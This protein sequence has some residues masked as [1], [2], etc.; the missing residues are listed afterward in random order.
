MDGELYE[1]TLTVAD[2]VGNERT[3]A[4][5]FNVADGG[6]SGSTPDENS[7][8]P[9]EEARQGGVGDVPGIVVVL[10]LVLGVIAAVL[11]TFAYRHR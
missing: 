9:A 6:E 8:V 4:V 1:A 10:L 7:D 2:R 3:Q 5:T 11:V